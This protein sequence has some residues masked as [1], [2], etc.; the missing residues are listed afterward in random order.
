MCFRTLCRVTVVLFAFTGLG[1]RV[2]SHIDDSRIS[3]RELRVIPLA[4]EENL[5]AISL[6]A[7][8]S[9]LCRLT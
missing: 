5:H 3:V 7:R 8:F 4:R 6:R 2:T 1:I 9:V